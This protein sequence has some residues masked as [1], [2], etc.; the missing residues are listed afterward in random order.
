MISNC[1]KS[2]RREKKQKAGGIYKRNHANVFFSHLTG[3]EAKTGLQRVA[4]GKS[5]D[6]GHI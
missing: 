1:I 5:E 4:V 3:T 6:E 2:T